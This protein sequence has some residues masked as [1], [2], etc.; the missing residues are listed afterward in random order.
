MVLAACIHALKKPSD[1]PE[2]FAVASQFVAVRLLAPRA[3]TADAAAEEP[4]RDGQGAAA[5]PAGADDGKPAE[6]ATAAAG[7]SAAAAAAADGSGGAGATPGDRQR[8]P[9]NEGGDQAPSLFK[10]VMSAEEREQRW[11]RQHVQQFLQG[12]WAPGWQ[13]E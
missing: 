2:L 1:N 5:S 11:F 7:D 3:A 6:A 9:E 10:E 13:D 4:E 8:Q 12:G